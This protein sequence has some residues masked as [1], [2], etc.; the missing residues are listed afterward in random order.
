MTNKGSILLPEG[1]VAIAEKEMTYL[2]GGGDL[3]SSSL[4]HKLTVTACANIRDA[5]VRQGEGFATATS[6]LATT[7]QI[8]QTIASAAILSLTVSA[9]V[10]FNKAAIGRGAGIFYE[11]YSGGGGTVNPGLNTSGYILKYM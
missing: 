1:G 8:P 6:I 3:I 11:V 10:F 7:G 2:E 5:L 4:R 9:S